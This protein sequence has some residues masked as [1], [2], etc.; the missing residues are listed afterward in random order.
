[1]NHQQSLIN[2]LLLSA[3]ASSGHKKGTSHS[4]GY[5]NDSLNTYSNT[6]DTSYVNSSSTFLPALL[7]ALYAADDAIGLN[8]EAT[9]PFVL[10][11]LEYDYNAL[12]PYISEETLRYHHD[13]LHQRYVD[14]LNNALERYP[15]FYNYTLNEFLLFPDRLP[16][17]VQA[18]ILN[19]A[20][21]HYN[22][23]LT[24]KLISPANKNVPTVAFAESI[25][26]QF[27]SFENMASIL[28]AAG[29]SVFGT[30]Y[31]WLTLNPYGRLL[32]VTTE[33]QLTP[34]PLRSIPLLPIDVWEHAYYLD[35]G[36]SRAN[37]LDNYFNLVDWQR[38][39]NR[40]TSAM[41]IFNNMNAMEQPPL[42]NS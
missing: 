30:G 31:A 9:G 6:Y 29:L 37:Y 10:S 20:G 23:T 7:A 26:E 8:P 27:G 2:L 17:D 1:M 16:S 21:G 19:N 40:Y 34:I 36:T 3:A 24:W 39:G 15:E 32:V 4:K 25:N 42:T 38:V 28:K 18:Q 41:T 33:E 5:R 13:C 22:H 11:P 12:E 14:L 35:T